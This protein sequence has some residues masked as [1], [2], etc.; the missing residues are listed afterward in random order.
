M[1]DITTF[2]ETQYEPGEKVTELAARIRQEASTCDFPAIKD[3]YI[4][5]MRQC[6]PVLSVNEA[7]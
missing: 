2:M 6:A 1:K 3:I 5:K 4:Y 7:V